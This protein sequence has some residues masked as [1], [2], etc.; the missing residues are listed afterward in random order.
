MKPAKQLEKPMTTNK[1][2]AIVPVRAGSRRLPNKNISDFGGTNLLNWKLEQLKK[3][4]EISKIVVSS[5]SDLMLE[6]AKNAGVETH[7]RAIEYCDEQTKSFG[8]V[9]QHIAESVD[10]DHIIWATCTAPL[11]EPIDYSN[12]IKSYLEGLEQG[13]DSLMSIE[14]FKRYLWNES[15]PINYKLG[16]EHVPSQQL[17]ELYFVTDGILIAPRLDMIKWSY[18]HGTNPVKF[19]LDK[20]KCVDIDDKLDLLVAKAW[21]SEL[22]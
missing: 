9:V 19:K 13:Y 5:D 18:F 14:P 1:F 22:K 7:K 3:V 4:P 8:E 11:V 12:A 21:L 2:T 6:I 20:V 16:K 10:G 17:E 15:G